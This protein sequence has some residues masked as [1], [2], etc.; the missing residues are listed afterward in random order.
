MKEIWAVARR[1]IKDA[2]RDSQVWQPVLLVPLI[3]SAVF[4]AMM[5][6]SPRMPLKEFSELPLAQL[7]MFSAVRPEQ[8]GIAI[9][10]R[11]LLPLIWILPAAVVGPIAASSF[12]GEK[13]QR[14]LEP[15]LASPLTDAQLIWGKVLASLIPGLGIA[16]AASLVLATVGITVSLSAFGKLLFPLTEWVLSGLLITPMAALM[17][18]LLTVSVSALASSSRGAQAIS[19]LVILPIMGMLIGQAEGFLTISPAFI[20]IVAA[21]MAAINA[22]L[23][24][25]ALGI[26][27][28]QTLME[29]L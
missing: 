7:P 4:S 13:E 28:R 10:P 20:W 18:L 25:V 1:E 24:R 8:L 2:F 19:V 27:R 22:V 12:V 11:M 29:R 6:F 9:V 3:L 23:A 5:I 17:V 16:W 21:V 15:L 26:F 14:T